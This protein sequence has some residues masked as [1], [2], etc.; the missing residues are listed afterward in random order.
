MRVG[1]G[2]RRVGGGRMSLGG[3]VGGR[4]REGRWLEKR[5]GGME[6]GRRR[7]GTDI[8]ELKVSKKFGVELEGVHVGYAI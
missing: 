2:R 4:R 8:F 3:R 7:W 1:R 5:G 6:R